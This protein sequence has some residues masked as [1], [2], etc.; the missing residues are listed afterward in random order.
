MELVGHDEFIREL[1]HTSNQN[2]A[3]R[4]RKI[5]LKNFSLCTNCGIQIWPLLAPWKPFQPD[6]HA[7]LVHRIHQ[8]P[9]AL[10]KSNHY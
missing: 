3:A 10:Y 7:A 2:S 1:K 9:L 6:S 5:E 4:S 8:L